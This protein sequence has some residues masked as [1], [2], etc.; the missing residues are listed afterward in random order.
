M[1]D[2]VLLAVSERI[3]NML[4]KHDTLARIGGDEFMIVLTNMDNRDPVDVLAKQLI[5]SVGQPL[6]VSSHEVNAGVSIGIC[7]YPEHGTTA[8]ELIKNA[9]IAMYK[10]KDTGRN[11]SYA[12]TQEL[13]NEIHYRSL[14]QKELVSALKNDQLSL[15]YQ[16]QFDID[17]MQVSCVEVLLRWHHENLGT[18]PPDVFIPLA[19]N[20]G[21]I[22]SVTD[23]V[24]KNALTDMT[25]WLGDFPEIKLAVNISALEFSPQL[26]LLTR[27]TRAITLSGF[28]T[29]NVE[30][31]LTET[32]FL[33]HPEHANFLAKQLSDI[34]FSI[35]LDD[36]GTG[37]ASLT[38]LVELPIDRIKIDRSFVDGVEDDLKKQAVVKG[39]L[40]ISNGLNIPCLGEGIET[41]EQLAWL[42]HAGCNGAQGYLLSKPVK[43]E[44]LVEV[45]ESYKNPT[46]SAA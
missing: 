32:A 14:L 26:D 23:W 20:C 3:K 37:Y 5:R 12:F 40:A 22:A 28:K 42:E 13:S 15:V 35:A 38:Y 39:I 7:K 1:G 17:T 4:T 43:V 9:D 11:Q 44:T 10:A 6:F 29:A 34:G 36:F 19:E 31:E 21:I 45:I 18:I 24:L 16:P 46:S 27:L 25:Q 30:I 8:E 2:Q 33:K 41:K